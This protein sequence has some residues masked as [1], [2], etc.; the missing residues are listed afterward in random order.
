M[1]IPGR[2]IGVVSTALFLTC[3]VASGFA[4]SASVG[5]LTPHHIKKQPVDFT[6]VRPFSSDMVLTLK[7]P[8]NSTQFRLPLATLPV[9]DASTSTGAGGSIIGLTTVP[10]FAGAFAPQNG[11]SLGNVFPFIMMGGDPL[12]GGT[13]TIPVDMTEVSLQLLNADGTTFATVPYAPFSNLTIH[14]PNFANSL[15]DSSL[16]ATQFGDAVQRAEFFTTGKT[17]WHTKLKA[18]VIVNKVTIAVPKTVQVQLS[19]GNIVTATSYFTGTASDGSTFVLMLDLLFNA[20][21]DNQVVNDINAGFFPPVALNYELFP[22]TF[23]FSLNTNNPSTPGGCCVLG[24]HTYFYEGGVAPQPRW[25]TIFASYISPGLFG[26]GFQ[27]ITGLSHETAESLN[28]PFLSNATPVWQFPG[29]PATSTDCQGNLETGDPIE[30]LANATV[31]I[32]LTVA[33]KPFTFHPQTE[34]LLQ[35]FE[36]GPTSNAVDGAYSY[37]NEA[38]LT[39][40]AVPCP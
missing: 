21:F 35:W 20:L 28:D 3:A 26:A 37:P 16:V 25:V 18:P 38:A 14:S 40:S 17:T 24:F 1:K 9:G 27:D 11:P 7:P 8:T 22:N 36:M 34:A 30:V 15:Y 19:N 4:Q 6:T 13:T 5:V 39:A 32:T 31:P 12:A 33:G 2:F 23:L 10:T 29:Q